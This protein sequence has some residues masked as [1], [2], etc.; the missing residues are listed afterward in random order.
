M[1]PD[2]DEAGGAGDDGEEIVHVAI[3]DELDLHT[4]LPRDVRSLVPEYLDECV[5]LGLREVRIVHGKGR[6]VLRRAVQAALERHP[7]VVAYRQADE[8]SGGWGATLV[9]LA[10][11]DPGGVSPASRR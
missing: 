10:P 4:F 3:G 8:I 11:A 5:R 9:T 6:G 1:S 7:C 2:D